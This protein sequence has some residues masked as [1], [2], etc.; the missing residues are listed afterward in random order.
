MAKH[1]LGRARERGI[2]K[3]EIVHAITEPDDIVDVKYDRKASFKHLEC[4]YLVVIYETRKGE[5]VVVKS[6]RVDKKRLQSMVSLEFDPDVNA[7]HLRFKKARTASSEP[8]VDN[9][10]VDL[11]SKYDVI[12]IE[13]LLPRS[14]PAELKGTIRSITKK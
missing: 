9:I 8:L 1:A 5:I 13:L 2:A 7:L 14:I 11:G 10:V 6:I 4:N 12:G 3:S